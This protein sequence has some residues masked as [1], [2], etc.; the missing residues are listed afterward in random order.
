MQRQARARPCVICFWKIYDWEKA[1]ADASPRGGLTLLDAE[2][3]VPASC[4]QL[5]EPALRAAGRKPGG[6]I[7]VCVPFLTNMEELVR[8]DQLWVQKENAA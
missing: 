7:T 4:A 3:T 2:M 5:K 6:G 1:E 8:G